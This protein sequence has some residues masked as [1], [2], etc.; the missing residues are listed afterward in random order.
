[1]SSCKTKSNN[2]VDKLSADLDILKMHD[3]YE[4]EFGTF[5]IFVN[6]KKIYWYS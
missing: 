1:M 3:L 5:F 2:E 6:K 4:D